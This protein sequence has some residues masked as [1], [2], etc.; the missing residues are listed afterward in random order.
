M[1]LVLIGAALA[2]AS[3]SGLAHAQPG[4]GPVSRNCTKDLAKY[5]AGK[6]HQNREA[7]ACLQAN[8]RKLSAA[9]KSALDTTGG[10]KG[11]RAR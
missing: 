10:G 8:K 11:R 2:L 3:M 7:R 9:C 5:C 1:R 4:P 6:S